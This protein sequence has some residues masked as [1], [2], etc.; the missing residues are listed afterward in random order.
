MMEPAD[1]RRL[2]DAFENSDWDEIRLC[3]DGTEILISANDTPSTLPVANVAIPAT[4]ATRATPALATATPPTASVTSDDEVSAT[5]EKSTASEIPPGD[6]VRSASPGIFWRSPAP[7]EPPFVEVGQHVEPDSVVCIVEVMKLMNRVTAG[8]GGTVAAIL[9]E[10][11][12][13]V[14]KDQPLMIVTPD[15]SQL[16]TGASINS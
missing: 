5:Q 8:V 4:Q 15:S 16:S 6:P 14:S 11:S 12:E 7:G 1:I 2:L 3:V 13:Q 10:N 9:V